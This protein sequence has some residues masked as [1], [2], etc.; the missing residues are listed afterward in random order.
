MRFQHPS[1]RR[2]GFTLVEMMVA[3]A[4]TV[5]IL[6]I[7][8]Q[9]FGTGLDTF[10][11]LKA[12]GDMQEGLR[13]VSVRLRADLSADHFE[14]KRRL[15]DPNFWYAG[16]NS[17]WGTIARP[18]MGFF[19]IMQAN[20]SFSEGFDLDNVPCYRAAGPGAG[21]SNHRLWFAVKLRGNRREDYFS[22]YVPVSSPLLATGATTQMAVFADTHWQLGPTTPPYTGQWAEV[23]YFLVQS[24]TTVEL[25]NTGSTVGTPLYTLYRAQR[26][27]VPDNLQLIGTVPF[28]QLSNYYDVSCQQ[29]VAPNAAS[30]YFN[31]PEDV[32][33]NNVTGTVKRGI[34]IPST[35]AAAQALPYCA[36]LLHNV[37]SFDVQV[38]KV[39]PNQTAQN[40]PYTPLL[41][42]TFGD[43]PS[44]AFDTAA[45]Q[46]FTTGY[47]IA[48]V[49]VMIRVWDL[50]TEQSRQITVIQDL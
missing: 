6:V 34:S 48:A 3:M 31:T 35:L 29:D 43:L 42:A 23:A 27:L 19:R 26:V 21:N 10:R 5:F 12:I 44:T 15:S 50:K 18:R 39:M 17:P 41:D 32:A 49:Q 14:E 1:Q 46:A 4:L 11:S 37:V 24:G 8:S 36:P 28:G 13:T 2:A 33:G 9:A 30:L 20:P 47:S 38:L 40:P 25:N 7:L 16:L 45:T 22:A